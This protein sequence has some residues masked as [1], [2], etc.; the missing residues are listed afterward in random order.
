MCH[1]SGWE[2][3]AAT[4]VYGR[5]HRVEVDVIQFSKSHTGNRYGVVFIDHLTKWPEDFATS[6]HTALTI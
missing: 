3:C 5:F 4:T 6:N 1:M 2:S